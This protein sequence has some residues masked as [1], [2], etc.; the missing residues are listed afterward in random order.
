MNWFTKN[1]IAASSAEYK[2]E[3]LDKDG[4]CEHVEADINLAYACHRENDSFGTVG[5][6]VCCKACHEQAA[7]AD[8]EKTEVCR[9]CKTVTKR[10]DGFFWRWYD[11]YAAQGDVPIFICDGCRDKPTHQ[12]RVRRDNDDRYAEFGD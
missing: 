7:N 1:I 6:W 4:G 2:K 11:F 10:K 9:D 5:S 3:L 8:G 12:A